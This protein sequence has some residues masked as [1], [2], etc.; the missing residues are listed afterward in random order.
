M[1]ERRSTGLLLALAT[2]V[3]SGFAVFLNGYGVKAVGDA[4][5]YTTAKNGVS[6]VVLLALAATIGAAAGRRGRL[7]LTRPTSAAQWWGLAAVGVL[8]GAVAFV[9]F[10]EGLARASST[11][12]AFLHKTLLIWVALLAVPILGE[13]LGVWHLLAIVLLVVG[14]V[15]LA[16]GV[17]ALVGTGQALVLGATLLWA[18]EVVLAKRLLADLSSWTVALARMGL[19]SVVLI[20][21]SVARGELGAVLSWSA[22]Q[23]GWVLLTGAILAGYVSTWFAALARAQAVDVTAILV[24]GAVIT[25]VLATAVQGV[26]L[27]PQTGW[28]LLV[29]AGGALMWAP[30]RQR[31]REVAV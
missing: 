12:S 7:P 18:V 16:G 23:W 5:L 31:T 26:P 22:S 15:G 20:L 14:Q 25:A 19:G 4:T 8:G 28:L 3:I 29:L 13:R 24:V 10:F 6:L 30:A 1:T 21:W 11:N 17:S 9:L 2:A 27:A